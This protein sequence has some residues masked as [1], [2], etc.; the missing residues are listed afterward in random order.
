MHFLYVV[1]RLR[2]PDM[3]RFIYKRGDNVEYQTLPGILAESASR[4]PNKEALAE[5]TGGSYRPITYSQAQQGVT[6]LAKGLYK[7]GIRRSDRVAILQ[8]NSPMWIISD[9][10]ILTLGAASVPL[11]PSLTAEQIGKILAD[12]GSRAIILAGSGQLEKLKKIIGGLPDMRIVISAEHPAESFPNTITLMYDSVLNLAKA[13]DEHES[14]VF[15][16]NT[17][18]TARDD[19]A[20]IIYTSGTTGDPKGVML[21]HGNFLSNVEATL[22]GVDLYPTDRTLSFLPLSH[23]LERTA[24]YYG[25]MAAGAAIYYAESMETIPENLLEVKPTFAVSVP[26]L[27][28][29]MHARIM[30]KVNAAPPKK[31]KL[32]HWARSVGARA[33]DKLHPEHDSFSVKMQLI[34]AK[35]LVHKKL[36]GRFGG[37]IRF[38]VSGGAPLNKDIARFFQSLGIKILE[39]YGLT[40]TSPIISFNRIDD[41]RPGTVGT[42]L[43]NVQVKIADDGE[44]LARGPSIMKGYYNNPEAT[45]EAIDE[46]GWFHTGDIGSLDKDG[47]LTITDRK[48]EIIVLSSGKNIAP[49]I[50]EMKLQ[51][52]DFINQVMV[53]GDK[54]NFVSAIIVPNFDKLRENLGIDTDGNESLISDPAINELVRERIENA[55]TEFARFEKIKKFTLLPRELTEKDGELTPT[56]KLKRRV[57]LREFA[58]QIEEMYAGSPPE[59]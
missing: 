44:I 7:L 15:I 26:R 19:L 21:T 56:L 18:K 55:T 22:R 28:E 51:A 52:D 37:N 23:V 40:E 10:A 17:K 53:V 46:D 36:A 29:K 57:I 32:F 50:I 20:S 4:Y 49:Q 12:S 1:P 43:D 24:G 58:E 27:F 16:E 54:R 14:D 11:Y 34:P 45:K 38:F 42:L 25:P 8:P 39:G 5:K 41:V 30:E 59:Q 2:G 3:V 47:Y 6:T 33:Y 48:K 35:K 9:M 13:M 31:Q